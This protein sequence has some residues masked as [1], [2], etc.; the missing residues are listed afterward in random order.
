MS[1][2]P[3]AQSTAVFSRLKEDSSVADLE[4]RAKKISIW[5]FD[6]ILSMMGMLLLVAAFVGIIV[7][8]ALIGKVSPGLVI[9]VFGLSGS[10]TTFLILASDRKKKAEKKALQKSIHNSRQTA[11]KLGDAIVPVL[12]KQHVDARINIDAALRTKLDEKGGKWSQ[13]DSDRIGVL[14]FRDL[15]RES[16]ISSLIL[17]RGIT[18]ASEIES[19]LHL[20]GTESVTPIQEGW[21]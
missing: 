11:K 13:P 4:K 8:I 21:L 12:T 15:M 6:S 14:L 5:V 19:A 1:T 20:M 9:L 3:Y 16:A 17:E 2:V 10:G 7:W 18:S